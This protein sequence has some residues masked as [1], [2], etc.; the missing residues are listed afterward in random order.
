MN[1]KVIRIIVTAAFALIMFAGSIYDTMDAM[2]WPGENLA[3]LR[4]FGFNNNGKPVLGMV[5][6]ASNDVLTA[7]KGEVIFSRSGNDT[8]SKLPSPLGAWT[9]IDH[10]DGLISIYSR[11]DDSSGEAIINPEDEQ[12]PAVD[13]SSLTWVEKQQPIARAGISGWS[14]VD[15]F[16]FIIYDRKERRWVNP[17][18]IITPMQE[19]ALPQILLLELRNEQGIPTDT[20]NISQGRYTI[21]VNAAS[22]P[23]S[24][25]VSLTGTQRILLA[26][27]RITCL[28]NGQEAGSLNFEAMTGRDGILMASRNGLVSANQIYKNFPAFEIADVFFTRG[29]VN[30]EV[31]V[32]DVTGNSRSVISRLIVN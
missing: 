23:S 27:Q 25:I 8:A 12:V 28:V 2:S 32:Q 18:M 26:P 5:F 10:G 29:Q 13:Y 7:E 1:K 31:I 3:L 17:A 6:S 4:N 14:S 22:V 16:Y 15:G 20:R 21:N 11:Y 19:T 30:I 9:A 24:N